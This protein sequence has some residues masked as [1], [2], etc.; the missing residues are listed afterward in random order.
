MKRT[1]RF[2]LYPIAVMNVHT[3]TAAELAAIWDQNHISKIFPSNVRHK[4]L[5][6]YL[7]QLK[8][9]G[10]RVDEVGR[11]G[12]NREIYQ[13]E[14]G[15]GKT[16]IFLWSQM[17]G[18]E[19]TA[20]SALLDIFAYLQKNRDKDWVKNLAE[21]LTLRAVPMLNPTARV[22]QG[23][24]RGVDITRDGSTWKVRSRL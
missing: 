13:M 12:Q 17:H 16:R 3:Q 11:S 5:K 18:D 10:I 15:K 8:K 24:T 4:D 19:P 20:T 22:Y 23:E 7:E 21:T 14:F 9:L 2:F 1:L 6:N